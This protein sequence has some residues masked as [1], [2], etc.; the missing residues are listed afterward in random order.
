M[1]C[2]L[3]Y[4]GAPDTAGSGLQMEDEDRQHNSAESNTRRS[5][6][7]G[8]TGPG[9]LLGKL[10][11]GDNTVFD[12]IDKNARGL[13]Q[14]A[15]AKLDVVSREEFDAQTR[16]LERTRGRVEALEAE[17]QRLTALLDEQNT[18]GSA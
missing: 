12:Q 14:N 6:R 13:A 7:S 4:I 8:P 16:V 9:E 11:G 3:G 17:L 1:S 18:G 5:T 10:L 2:Q 15:L